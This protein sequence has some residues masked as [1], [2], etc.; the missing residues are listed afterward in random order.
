MSAENQPPILLRVRLN[1]P[2]VKTFVCRYAPNIS[3]GGLFIQSRSPQAVGTSLH[4]E[5]M[6]KEGTRLLAGEGVVVWIKAHDPEQP[7]RPHGMGIRFTSLDGASRAMLERILAHKAR[8]HIQDPSRSAISGADR[9]AEPGDN[10]AAVLTPSSPKQAPTTTSEPPSASEPPSTS[11]PPSASEPPSTSADVAAPAAGSNGQY[12]SSGNGQAGAN[13]TAL[14]AQPSASAPRNGAARHHGPAA[15]RLDLA[16]IDKEL[17][18]LASKAGISAAM[19]AEILRRSRSA[20]FDIAEVDSFLASG[21]AGA[22]SDAAVGSERPMAAPAASQA[23]RTSKATAQVPLAASPALAMSSSSPAVASSWTSIHTGTALLDHG[24]AD[25]LQDMAQQA[26]AG[27]VTQDDRRPSLDAEGFG[28]S[29][30]QAAANI[31]EP[32]APISLVA[33]PAFDL[34]DEEPSTALG[35]PTEPGIGAPS[36]VDESAL[37]QSLA[38]TEHVIDAELPPVDDAELPPV[39]AEETTAVDGLPAGLERNPRAAVD[40]A[41]R[42][43]QLAAALADSHMRPVETSAPADAEPPSLAALAESA[44]SSEQPG[45]EADETS[46]LEDLRVLGED[47]PGGVA[48]AAPVSEEL[49]AGQRRSGIFRRLFSRKDD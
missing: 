39:D 9:L 12:S 41:M 18:E 24:S 25:V 16:A 14:S 37:L 44:A 49:A 33:E 45:E 36:A 48:T 22:D 8:D 5:L 38:E 21:L 28:P 30:Q 43:M 7:K 47:V 40:D 4:F 20:S 1:Y 46:K 31:T 15:L 19:V 26:V 42:D 11:E 2:D 6:L 32:D 17:D 10:Q 3:A 34:T 13:G 27:Q 23:L 35:A 29:A